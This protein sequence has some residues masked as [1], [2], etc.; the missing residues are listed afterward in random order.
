MLECLEKMIGVTRE[1]CD[2]LTQGLTNDEILELQESNSGLFIDEV[3][4]GIDLKTVKGVDNCKNLAEKML[5]ARDK[6]ITTLG[7]DLIIAISNRYD[8]AI[9]PYKGPIGRP[10]YAATLSNTRQF[11]GIRLR[12]KYHTDATVVLKRF[13]IIG[14]N[15]VSLDVYIVR[16]EEGYNGTGGVVVF[17]DT[18]NTTANNY[19]AVTLP[20]DAQG[21]PG[22]ELPLQEDG[23]VYE[24]WLYWDKQL[25]AFLP[26]DTSINCNC[27]ST[28]KGVLDDYFTIQGTSFTDST[29][30]VSSGTLDGYSHGIVLDVE[31]ICE[32]KYFICREY[33]DNEKVKVAMNYAAVYKAAELTIEAVLKSSEVNRFTL[34]NKEY[35]WGKRNHFRKEYD[36][37]VQ[38]AAAAMDPNNSDCFKCGQRK[39]FFEKIKS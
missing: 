6:A 19:T 24:Y 3:E 8:K 38:F 35:L 4:G 39:V 2:C 25:T 26:K 1:D 14:N 28:A 37:R 33:G 17:S 16:T 5:G 9:G 12:P 23:K 31:I 30:M 18:I 29:A 20:N 34:Q 21:N 36:Q 22:L 11:Q 32:S 27:S 7:D 15:A 13:Q 10:S